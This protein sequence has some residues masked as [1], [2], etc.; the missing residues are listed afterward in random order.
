MNPK[1]QGDNAPKMFHG[2]AV[3]N[4]AY[5]MYAESAPLFADVVRKYIQPGISYSLADLGSHKG[6]FLRDLLN[7]LPEYEF[8]SIAVDVNEDDLLDNSADI[9]I[10]SDL[11]H[12]DIPEKSIDVVVCRYVLAWNNLESQHQIIAEMKRIG[13]TIGIIQ[14]QGAESQ[15][16][17]PLQSAS[18]KLFGGAIPQLQRSEFFFSTPNQI[19]DFFK[20]QGIE[21]ECIQN[22]K[23]LGL[24][25]LL[26]EKYKL[27]DTDAQQVSEILKDADY[28]NQT[29]WILKF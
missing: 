6:A 20:E 2:E 24:S 4:A 15:D 17:D 11:G 22:R 21:F 27:S 1:E 26:I 19:E 9:K 3:S 29:T 16:P 25:E 23:V 12:I 28:V 5:S 7:I 10:K 13:R 14:H 18:K 8:H